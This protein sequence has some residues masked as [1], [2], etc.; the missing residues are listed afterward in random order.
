M[1]LSGKCSYFALSLNKLYRVNTFSVLL[2]QED[3]YGT[4]I[5]KGILHLIYVAGK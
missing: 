2:K 1:E 4:V 5:C 3:K